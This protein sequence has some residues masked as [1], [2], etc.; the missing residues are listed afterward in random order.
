M[1]PVGVVSLS[2]CDEEIKVSAVEAIS[3][4]QKIAYAP[5]MFQA[6]RLL[7]KFGIL[8]LIEE[9]GDDGLPLDA[10][11]KQTG[12]SEYGID[13]LLSMGLSARLVYK[14]DDHFV[15]SKIGYFLLNDEMTRINMNFTHDV[16][17]QAMFHLEEGH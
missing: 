3:E 13:V 12:L 7:C 9:S 14:K 15:I 11:A 10:I 8:R 16:C 2:W 6:S 1:L 17:Y 5:I 4:A